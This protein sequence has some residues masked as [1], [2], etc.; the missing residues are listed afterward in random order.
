MDAGHII[1]VAVTQIVVVSGVRRCD[2]VAFAGDLERC[3]AALPV[4]ENY[5]RAEGCVAMRLSQSEA[6][7]TSIG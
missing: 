6:G 4:L 7:V 1:G 5:A 2:L 3:R